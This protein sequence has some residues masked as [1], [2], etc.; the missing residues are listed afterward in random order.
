MFCC[1]PDHFN[2]VLLWE[3]LCQIDTISP[4]I[5]MVGLLRLI[6]APKS[7][8]LTFIADCVF[9]AQAASANGISQR[10]HFDRHYFTRFLFFSP[11]QK[12]SYRCKNRLSSVILPF[13]L[14]YHGRLAGFKG[15]LPQSFPRATCAECP[16]Q[17]LYKTAAHLRSVTQMGGSFCQWK[18]FSH[19]GAA[20]PRSRCP[21]Y[22][23]LLR[24]GNCWVKQ[25]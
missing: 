22:P 3:E 9:H 12:K 16:V 14:L 23:L 6:C 15:H 21:C 19:P 13:T 10:C 11:I 1:T 5:S 20:A 25:N 17:I 24:K 18:F 2:S 7:I 8:G 4:R